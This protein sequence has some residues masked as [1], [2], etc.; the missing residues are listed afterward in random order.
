MSHITRTLLLVSLC[1]LT[2]ACSRPAATNSNA[3]A[4]EPPQIA[5][6]DVVEATP[7]TT[8]LTRG[9]STDALVPIKITHGYHVNANPPSYPY[10]K[11]LELQVQPAT[12]VSVEFITYPDPLTKK[13]AFAE[14]P[15]AV[16]EGDTTVKIRLKADK[17]ATPGQHNLSAKLRVQACDDKVCY[18]PGE[19][20]LIVPV[21]VK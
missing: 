8:T 15:L 6:V 17:S 20:N 9:E 21:N 16:Y 2:L 18:A 3:T 13:F 10:L 7:A 4:N 1:W 12:G 14:K 11:P 5:S 19:E